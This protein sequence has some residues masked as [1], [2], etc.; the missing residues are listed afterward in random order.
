MFARNVM[1]LNDHLDD[2]LINGINDD[3]DEN[4]IY[5]PVSCIFPTIIRLL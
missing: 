3:D 4:K 5:I 1:W 2:S